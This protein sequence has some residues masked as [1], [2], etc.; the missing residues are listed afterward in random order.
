MIVK[1]E[2]K[3]ICR[4]LDS[5]LPLIDYWVIVDTGSKDGTQEIIKRY[6]K[7]KGIPGEL[8]ERPWKNFAHNRNEALALAAGKSDYVLFIDADDAFEVQPQFKMPKLD[9]TFYYI[10]I[11][12]PGLLYPRIQ[13]IKNQKEWKYVGVCHEVLPPLP[14][15][16]YATLDGVKI[17]CTRDGARSQDPKKY[18]KDAQVLEQ[19]LLDEPN[20]TRYMFY[21]AQSYRDAGLLEK[22]LTAYQ[23]RIDAG[24][25]DEEVFWSKLQLAILT[26]SLNMPPNLIVKRYKEA[27]QYRPIRSEPLYYLASYYRTQE[28]FEMC[29]KIAKLGINMPMP[30]DSLFVQP[31][32]YSYSLSL[33]LSIAAYWIGKYEECRA[34]SLDLLTQKDLPQN[35]RECVWRN[36]GFANSKLMDAVLSDANLA[37]TGT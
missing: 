4:C 9:K 31:W 29:Y 19:A 33:E 28:N 25:W 26:Q 27:Y 1:D 14:G 13:L 35:V 37:P 34:I 8:H 10:P 15:A 30:T 20:N 2:S 7:Q 36:L 5:A 21:L 12:L 32:V 22:S 24:G 18:E 6:M 11:E 23:R 16:T 17:V 3:V